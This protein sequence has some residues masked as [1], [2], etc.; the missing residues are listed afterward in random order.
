MIFEKTR[1]FRKAI[2]IVIETYDPEDIRETAHYVSTDKIM[3]FGKAI[4][5]NGCCGKR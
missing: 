3:W 1:V 4:W 2:S 5:S